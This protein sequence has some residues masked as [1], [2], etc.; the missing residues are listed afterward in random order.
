MTVDLMGAKYSGCSSPFLCL[1]R[2]FAL[3]ASS[4]MVKYS[5]HYFLG[6]NMTSKKMKLKAST[7]CI[8]AVNLSVMNS[9]P[10]FRELRM[11]TIVIGM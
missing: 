1:A 7:T 3:A 9:F 11:K 2:T 5:G 10:L 8:T 6:L 4:P